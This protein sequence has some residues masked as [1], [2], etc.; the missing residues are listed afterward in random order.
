[1]NNAKGRV[2]LDVV[3]HTAW[4]TIDNPDRRNA[5]TARMWRQ[6][7]ELLT[8]V[9][10][11]P[12][13][14][15]VVLTG[16]GSTFCAGA[17]ISE[18]PEIEGAAENP[19]VAAEQALLSCPL[20]TIALVNGLC[21]GGGCQLAA[22]CDIRVSAASAEF[23]ITPAKLGIVY[24]PSSIARL[25]ELVGPSAAKLLL[26][27]ADFVDAAHAQRMRLV[28][29][30]VDDPRERVEQLAATIASR[31]QL[32]VRASKELV[33]LAHRGLPLDDA[34]A[35]WQRTSAEAGE[36]AEGIAAFLERRPPEFPYGR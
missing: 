1:M 12:A 11:D 28:D 5:M 20:P 22:A 8:A 35:R 25:T 4:I 23:G 17:D 26:F 7:P 30:V 19:T 16:A 29:E 6:V 18:L 24:P 10:E 36:S 33:D 3:G 34:A 14:R 32:T 13:V 9:A 27:S 2:D 21:V 31:S 15:V